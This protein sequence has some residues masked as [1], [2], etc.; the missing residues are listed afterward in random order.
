MEKFFSFINLIYIYIC[1][2]LTH[3][4]TYFKKSTY[5]PPTKPYQTYMAGQPVY[6]GV[7]DPRLG[8]IHDKSDPGYFGHIELARPVYH[9]GFLDIILKALRCACFHCS[10]ITLEETDFRFRKA[11]CIKNR[12]RRLIAMHELI[13]PKRKCDHCNGVQPKYTRV[14]LHVEIEFADEMERMPG[15]SGDKKQFLSAQKAVEIL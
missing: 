5:P 8:D 12:K 7:N 1:H 3:C 11:K 9:Y 14:G 2:N 13:R 4:C 6:G 15:S 10:R